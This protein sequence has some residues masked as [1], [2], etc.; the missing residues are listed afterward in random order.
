MKVKLT[1]AERMLVSIAETERNQ[2]LAQID[3]IYQARVKSLLD[4]HGVDFRDQPQI[5]T[6]GPEQFLLTLESEPTVPLPVPN[7]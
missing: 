4:S 7:V 6:D 2:A 5:V 1:P 3:A